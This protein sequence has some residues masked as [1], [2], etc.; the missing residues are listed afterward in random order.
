[1][2]ET[3]R[4]PFFDGDTKNQKDPLHNRPQRET[5]TELH[6]ANF[7]RKGKSSKEIADLM[8]LSAATVSVHR[9]SIRKKLGSQDKKLKP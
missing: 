9:N 6:V 7:I 8:K 2:F 3:A 1:L 5:F 4:R